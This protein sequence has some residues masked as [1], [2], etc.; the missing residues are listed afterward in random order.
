[1]KIIDNLKTGVRLSVGFGLLLVIFTAIIIYMNTQIAGLGIIQDAGSQRSK[2][3]IRAEEGAGMAAKLYEVIA[4]TQINLNFAETATTWEDIKTETNG[5]LEYLANAAD[6]DSEK[7]LIQDASDSFKKIVQTYETEMLPALK[8]ANGSTPETMKMDSEI[9][10]YTKNMG[11]LLSDFSNSLQA[12]NTE[13]DELFDTTR[14]RVQIVSITAGIFSVIIAIILSAVITLSMTRPLTKV[15]GIGNRLSNGDLVRDMSEKEKDNVRL[16]KDEIGDLG[17]AFDN[18]MNYMQEM[19]TA[20]DTI[21]HNDL[22]VSIT[23]KSDKDEL[24]KAFA[25]MIKGL[26]ETVTEIN[27]NSRSLT[28]ASD[29]LARASDQA[30][31]ATNQISM[32]V[33]QIAKGTSDQ[34]ESI[35]KTASSVEQMSSA[36]DGVAKGAQEQSKAISIASDIT[37][38]IS[39]AIQQVAGNAAAVTKD[40]ETAA[41]AARDGSTTVEETLKGMQRIKTKVGASAEKVQEMGQRSGEIGAI[42]ETIEDIASQTNLLA[43]NAAIE[44]ARAGEHG[45]GFAVVADEVRKLA[46]RSSS[47]TKEIANLISGIQNTVAEAVS[48]MVE[49]SREVEVG[50]ESANKA[51]SALFDILAAAEAVNKQAMQAGEATGKM[52]AFASELVSAVDTVSAVVEE[53]TAA[54]EEMAANSTEVTQSIESIASV[55]EENSAAI[56]EV[57]ASTEEMSAQ[58]EEVTASAQSLSSMAQ[59]LQG[60]VKSFRLEKPSHEEMLAEIETFKTAH[61]HWLKKAE[62]MQNGGEKLDPS[63]LPTERQCALGRWYYGVGKVEYGQIKEFKD[64]EDVHKNCHT[65]LREFAVTYLNDGSQKS[66]TALEQLKSNSNLVAES[67]EQLKKVL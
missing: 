59:T 4:D 23:Q 52:N 3:A 19:G 45:K 55:S 44:A 39:T 38:Q 30:S 29:Q 5:D 57:S 61:L 22:T 6:T 26:R 43:L 65:R 40:S 21:A 13:A 67:L 11:E 50:V 20:A 34:A 28:E 10:T 46:E 14:S 31:Q 33:Q 25:R 18:L 16:R 66:V 41:K 49:G 2:D 15:V 12:E 42:V 7:T 17:R 9:D 53:N 63:N 47:A 48:A 54:T 36:I 32:T 35:N 60:I 27:L 37:Q 64:I 24:G 58:V 51:G 62:V 8:A 1:M 56:E